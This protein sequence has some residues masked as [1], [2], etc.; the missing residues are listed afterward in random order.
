MQVIVSDAILERLCHD[1]GEGGYDPLGMTIACISNPTKYAKVQHPLWKAAYEAAQAQL[2]FTR[3]IQ[4]YAK[5]FDLNVLSIRK[6]CDILAL[7]HE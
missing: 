5:K 7:E 3:R 1:G 4:R 2:K 6:T